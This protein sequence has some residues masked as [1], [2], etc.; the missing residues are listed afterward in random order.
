MRMMMRIVRFREGG[1][2]IIDIM[3]AGEDRGG[4]GVGIGRLR[5]R[6]GRHGR[7]GGLLLGRLRCISL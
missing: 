6:R 2:G 5:R 7:R 3:E 1:G 4:V